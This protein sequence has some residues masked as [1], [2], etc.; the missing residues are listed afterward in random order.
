[1]K[2][3]ILALALLVPICAFAQTTAPPTAIEV[4][5]TFGGGSLFKNPQVSEVVTQRIGIL[6]D[7][8]GI[9]GTYLD[10]RV[11]GGFNAS[12]SNAPA[13]GMTLAAY[14]KLAKELT[15]GLGPVWEITQQNK[16]SYGLY[17]GLSW[18][19]PSK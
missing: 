12:L 9:K 4:V 16:P 11:F 17:V 18:N 19:F 8:A 13:A 14:F 3:L 6:H 2:K 7:L 15:L 5:T 1:M 10:W